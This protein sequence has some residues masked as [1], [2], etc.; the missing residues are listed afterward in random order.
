MSADAVR[1]RRQLIGIAA[2]V[3]LPPL[4]RLRRAGGRFEART[5]LSFGWPLGL[6][7]GR[8]RGGGWARTWTSVSLGLGAVAATVGVLMADSL[9]HRFASG[10]TAVAW[11]VACGALSKS[12]SIDAYC[13]ERQ[14]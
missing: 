11:A 4:V 14:A 3:W 8:G 7:G 9:A 1:G 6:V 2:A 13:E 10:L 12:E 5:L